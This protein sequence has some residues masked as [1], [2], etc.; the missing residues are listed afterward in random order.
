MSEMYITLHANYN[1]KIVS[2][3]EQ[4]Y[5]RLTKELSPT[6]DLPPEHLRRLAHHFA[7]KLDTKT[8][9]SISLTFRKEIRDSLGGRLF[10]IVTGGGKIEKETMLFLDRTFFGNTSLGKSQSSRVV[11]AYV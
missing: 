5:P 9:S 7:E 2:W 1:R 11:N 6:K 4:T 3:F 8:G 10:N